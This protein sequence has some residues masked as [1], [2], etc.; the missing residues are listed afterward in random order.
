MKM[1]KI[2]LLFSL[3]IC[4]LTAFT[5]ETGT[6]TDA[7]DGK[8]YKTVVIAGQ[9]WLAENLAFKLKKDCFAYDNDE[10][11]VATYGY[12]YTW[13][14]AKEAC[15]PGWHIPSQVEWF[16]LVD[17]VGHD[18]ASCKLKESGTSHWK[19]PNEGATNETGFT[20]LPGGYWLPSSKSFQSKGY[21][22]YWWT[23]TEVSGRPYYRYMNNKEGIIAY[24]TNSK[25][26]MFSVRLIK[27]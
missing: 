13:K 24:E 12:L 20:A 23:T 5:Q 11:N 9:T 22:G 15:P 6:F 7:R 4:C 17:F 27:D 10:N 21:V 1:R 18:F 3:I 16:A 25:T 19:A 2:T 8:V 26:L 14:A